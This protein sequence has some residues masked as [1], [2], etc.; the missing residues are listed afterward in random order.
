MPSQGLN[1]EQDT[2]EGLEELDNFTD[3][4]DR[5]GLI[6]EEGQGLGLA[7]DSEHRAQKQF[8][9]Q[10]KMLTARKDV[11]RQMKGLAPGFGKEEE[12]EEPPVTSSDSSLFEA[13]TPEG[14][15]SFSDIVQ[16]HPDLADM[17]RNPLEFSL[18]KPP[19][20]AAGGIGEA[21]EG[22]DVIDFLFGG[23]MA[24]LGIKHDTDGFHASVDIATQQWSEQ[25]AWI[26]LLNLTSLVGTAFFPAAKAFHSSLKFGKLGKALPGLRKEAWQPLLSKGDELQKFK[27][28]K[29]LDESAT[30]DDLDDKTLGLLR[31]QEYD[32]FRYQELAKRIEAD[33]KGE[34]KLGL[35]EK[36]RWAFDKRFA[37]TYF[38]LNESI[39]QGMGKSELRDRFVTSLDELWK[40][41]DLGRWFLDIPDDKHGDKIAMY[42]MNKMDPQRFGTVK[43]SDK[44]KRWADNMYEE[45]AAHQR[46]MLAEGAITQKTIARIGPVHFPAQY[47]GTPPPDVSMGQTMLLP[48][49]EGRRGRNL[50]SEAAER[51]GIR[52][53]LFGPG[54]DAVVTSEKSSRYIGLNTVDIPRLTFETMKKRQKDLPEVYQR[55]IN[56]ELITDT[57]DMTMRGFVM[58]RL[59]LTSFRTARDVI[60]DPGTAQRAAYS[61]KTADILEQY[62]TASKAAKAGYI[63]LENSLPKEV[64]KTLKRMIR[65]KGGTDFVDELPWMHK[66]VF[67]ELFGGD[68]TFAQVQHA[69][70]W[71]DIATGIHKTSKTA[72]SIPTHFQN[73]AGNMAM[74]SQAGFNPLSPT[75]IKIQQTMAGAFNKI[76]E[77][78]KAAREAGKS[79][80]R[81]LDNISLDLG[82]MKIG[83]RNFNLASELLDP[84]VRELIE[85]SAFE[86]VEG[87]AALERAY[88]RLKPEQRATKWTAEMFIGAKK[89]LQ[90]G[91][92]KGFKWFDQMTKAYLGEDMVPKMSYYMALRGKGLSKEAAITEVARRLP[93]YNSVGSSIKFGRRFLFPWATFPSE[94][95]R[96]TKNNMLDHPLRMMPWIKMPQ[97][98]QATLAATGE[99]PPTREAVQE[100][101]RFLPIWAQKGVTS[102]A[103]SDVT[104]PAGGGFTGGIAGAVAGTI[105]GG[106]RG[107]AVGAAAGALGGAGLVN[108][109]SPQDHED[110]MRGIVM[111][112]LPH[113]SFM[114]S[115]DSP[116]IGTNNVPWRDVPSFLSQMPAE[117]LAIARPFF[118]IAA[119][120]TGFGSEIGYKDPGDAFGKGIA[121]LIGFFMPPVIQ[122]YGFKITTPD[123]STTEALF[124]THVP[125]DITNISRAQTESGYKLDVNSGRVG[126]LS[127]D[128]LL[129]NFGILK[130]W[131]ATP[132]TRLANMTET[133][134]YMERIRAHMGRQ[135][136]FFIENGDDY[137]V[138]QVLSEIMST[139]STQYVDDPGLA[140]KKYTEYIERRLDVVGNH[141]RL[142]KWS[143]DEMLRRLV[144][145]SDFAA[146]QRMGARGTILDTLRKE[147]LVRNM[148]TKA[149]KNL[150]ASPLMKPNKLSEEGKY[151]L[152]L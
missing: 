124:G 25:P 148:S 147:L 45:M 47:K 30:I 8:M 102:L 93:M 83:D 151:G 79:T 52:K 46:E 14:Y 76:A 138:S 70:N 136:A 4:A 38:L 22:T 114:L 75:N 95:L 87:Y 11:A 129:N 74:L 120:R 92:R 96:I 62:G 106:P 125:G 10:A 33:K 65:K 68:G 145:A 55:L 21:V 73:L 78:H 44:V 77:V 40:T 58:D 53:F 116:E 130:S 99:G 126:N 86:T 131:V 115:S 34:L 111:D 41:E 89:A 17:N 132:E 152:G 51:T 54:K 108:A 1:L 69:V 112:W 133:E 63:S 48:V 7:Q 71:L 43:L 149:G 16:R 3:V 90:F 19:D 6:S 143:K 59:I 85:E 18:V 88:G 57:A 117:P 144:M 127:H 94:A 134:R 98:V 105:R 13:A 60:M 91:D 36:L 122:K 50:V 37:N 5:L 56:G 97:I 103:S 12:P 67:D 32:R 27:M 80:R 142:K 140:Q 123:V 9:N 81:I 107:A 24:I 64:T 31:R 119:G 110:T 150:M 82:T 42:W 84:K 101:K 109:L 104:G 28:N 100:G 23:E 66:S 146:Q 128:M 113:S 15:K 72:L 2:N 29:M 121:G 139:F 26:N 118:E 49:S 141:P 39:S 20:Y 35:G 61:R 135:L 137:K